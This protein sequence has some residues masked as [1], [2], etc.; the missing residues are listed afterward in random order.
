MIVSQYYHLYHL[1]YYYYDYYYDL[2]D[3]VF[4]CSGQLVSEQL[5]SQKKMNTDLAKF[6]NKL[7][8]VDAEKDKLL[9][10][11]E[12]E[13]RIRDEEIALLRHVF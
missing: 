1:Y 12:G 3:N 11:K 8:I 6:C 10:A 2:I 5:E 13:I 4:Y 9:F 7:M